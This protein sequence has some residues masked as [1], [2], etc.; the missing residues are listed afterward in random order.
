LRSVGTGQTEP[1]TAHTRPVALRYKDSNQRHGAQASRFT[2][3]RALALEDGYGPVF[4][5]FCVLGAGVTW[6]VA[7]ALAG[8]GTLC[9]LIGL[10]NP[11]TRTSFAWGATGLNAALIVVSYVLMM[12][13]PN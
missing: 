8:V 7:L 13:P 4:K 11:V 6:M 10:V 3:L 9:G 2:Y 1:T 5:L 12:A